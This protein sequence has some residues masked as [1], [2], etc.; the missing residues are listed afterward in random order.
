MKID[1]LIEKSFT[2][3]SVFKNMADI[4]EQVLI[5]GYIAVEGDNSKILGIITLKDY[6]INNTAE[7]FNSDINKP[8]VRPGHTISEVRELMKTSQ[9][10]YLPVYDADNFMGVVSVGNITD[11][12]IHINKKTRLNYQKVIHDIRNPIANI[13]GIIEIISEAVNDKQSIAMLELSTQSCK[14]AM[15]ILDDLLFVELDEDK[16]L[17]LQPTEM[18]KFFDECVK[19]QNGIA[20]QKAIQIKTE[21]GEGTIIKP[22]DRKQFKRAI[23]N[24]MSNAIKFSVSGSVV[25]ISSKIADD[26]ITLKIVDSGIGIPENLQGEIFNKFNRAQRAGTNGEASTGLGLCF[27]KQCLERHQGVIKFK[28]EVGKGTKFYITI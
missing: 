27:T 19:E 21:F 22:I 24:I 9:S 3:I 28:S 16:P 12:L 25:K 23:Q 6:H 7:I 5:Q 17:I 8:K 1:N 18:T 4:A 11:R 20:F 26:K 15:D 2:R 10:D 14:H 13:Q